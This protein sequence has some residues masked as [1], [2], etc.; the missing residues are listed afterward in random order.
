M[1]K[2]NKHYNFILYYIGLTVQIINGII[3]LFYAVR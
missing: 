1:P 3:R 2:K